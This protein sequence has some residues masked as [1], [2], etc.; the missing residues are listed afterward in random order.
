MMKELP[1]VEENLSDEELSEVFICK[2]EDIIMTLLQS[3]VK[4]IAKVNRRKSDLAKTLAARLTVFADFAKETPSNISKLKEFLATI[5]VLVNPGEAT[6]Q[7]LTIAVEAIESL[8]EEG[9]TLVE[10]RSPVPF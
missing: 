9:H 8:T 2:I 5:V 10:K 4:E 3:Y 6:A 1:L 7:E